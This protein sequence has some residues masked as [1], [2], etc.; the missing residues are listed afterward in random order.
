MISILLLANVMF[1][2][3]VFAIKPLAANL[4]EGGLFWL[5]VG[6]VAYTLGAIIYSIKQIKFNH[7]IFHL[8]VLVGSGSHF[9]A[10]YFY[11]LESS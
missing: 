5:G 11:V 9:I 7:A 8:F 2:I 4:P 10:I 3:M 6:G 1:W